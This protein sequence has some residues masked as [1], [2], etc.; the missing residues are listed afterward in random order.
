MKL[1]SFKYFRNHINLF[2]SVHHC[3]LNSKSKHNNDQ[4][5]KWTPA[6]PLIISL[7]ICL[8]F[9]RENWLV[10]VL[11]TWSVT[12][13]VGDQK[14]EFRALIMIS[15]AALYFSCGFVIQEHCGLVCRRSVGL[16]QKMC[17]NNEHASRNLYSSVNLLL[18]IFNI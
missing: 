2:Y 15:P 14:S 17:L 9:Q 8:I 4:G 12:T 7:I 10:E 1:K 11:I 13:L 3:S 6:N 16:S 18:I 5:S